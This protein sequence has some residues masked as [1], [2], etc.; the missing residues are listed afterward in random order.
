[1]LTMLYY[2]SGKETVA[3]AAAELKRILTQMDPSLETAVCQMEERSGNAGIWLGTTNDLS[4]TG[5][6]VARPDL[7]DGYLIE[8]SG[9]NGIIAGVNPRSVLLAVYRYLRELGCAW[10][11][12]GALGEII[13]AVSIITREVHVSEAASSRHRGVCIEGAASYDHVTEMIRW[14]PKIGMNAYFNQFWSPVTFYDRWYRHERNPTLVPYP[15]TREEVDGFVRNQLNDVRREDMLYHATGHGWT[16]EPFGFDSCGWYPHEGPLP[17][18]AEEILAMVNGKRGLHTDKIPLNTNLCYTNPD[19]REKIIEGITQYCL[20]HKEVNYLHF[21]L[22]DAMNNQCECPECV[23][24][25]PSDHYV[26]ML[27][28]LDERMTEAGVAAR[29]VFLIYFDLMW[30]PT[31]SR[32]KNEDR[33]VLMFAPI[34]RTYSTAYVDAGIDDSVKVKPFELNKISL[35]R[36]VSENVAFLKSWKEVFKGDSF[37]FDYH[38]WIDHLRDIGYAQISEV[39]FKDMKGLRQLGLNGMVSCQAQRVFFPSA[40]PMQLMAD[41]LWNDS[42]DYETCV[43][44]H[45]RDMYAEEGPRVRAYL[46]RVSALFDSAYMRH[47]KPQISEEALRNLN[48][49]G[50]LIKEFMPIINENLN[51]AKPMTPAARHSFAILKRHGELAIILAGAHACKAAGDMDTAKT[52]WEEAAAFARSHEME[53]NEV[54]DVHQFLMIMEPA[55]LSTEILM[56]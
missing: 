32:I 5:P 45:Y 39:L 46:E 1:M 36:S 30:R 7:D 12:P 24:K 34:T 42:V 14:L 55:I 11:R 40:L 17:E 13:P 26:D 21:W 41:A 3:F 28:M 47:E 31:T 35:P 56:I 44:K 54:F 6:A 2:I 18:G 38:L 23:K 16:C 19:V 22:A 20:R 8:M 53:L 10:I 51:P 9:V 37:I 49:A 25:T 52:L 33:F 29:V 48:K 4:V 43:Q 27:N 15:L 50:E